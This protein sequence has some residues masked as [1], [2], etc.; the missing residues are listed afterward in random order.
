MRHSSPV[1]ES[2]VAE[3]H[4]EQSPNVQSPNVQSP[5]VQSPNEQSPNEQSPVLEDRIRAAVA[6]V[7]D[8]ELAGVSIGDLGLVSSVLSNATGTQVELIPTFLGCPALDVIRRDVE[9]AVRDAGSAAVEVRFLATVPWSPDRI[10]ARGRVQLAALG[11]G[12]CDGHGTLRCPECSSTHLAVRSA[13]GA[14]ACRSVAWCG[15]CRTPI[16]LMR[17]PGGT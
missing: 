4:L 3:S 9:Q 6:A 12:V 8:P 5:N 10:S 13:V 15:A 17:K 2:H 14:T 16:D 1:A 7:L 11:I